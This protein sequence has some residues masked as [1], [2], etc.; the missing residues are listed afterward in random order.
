MTPIIIDLVQ[1]LGYVL[2]AAI[3]GRVIISWINVS[4]N[5][6]IVGIIYKVTEPILGPIRRM[7]PSMGGLDL[8]PMVALILVTVFQR[9]IFFALRA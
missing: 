7:L 1:V 2:Y 3:I 4:P 8:A 6:P 9:I 5:N